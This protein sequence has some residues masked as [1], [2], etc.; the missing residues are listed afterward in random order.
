MWENIKKVFAIIGAVLSVVLFTVILF[1]LRRR[2]SDG[3]GSSGID[4]RDTRIKEGLDGA[5]ESI[6]DSRDT[7]ERCEERL[8]RAEEILRGAI[9][10]GEKEKH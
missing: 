4:E 5:Q 7:T 2:S 3:Q 8:R 9:E 10:R 1:L 6:R